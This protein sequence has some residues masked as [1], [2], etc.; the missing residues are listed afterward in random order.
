MILQLDV[1][2]IPEELGSCQ[3]LFGH[4]NGVGVGG[5]KEDV[6][7]GDRSLHYARS[8]PAPKVAFLHVPPRRTPPQI[9]QKL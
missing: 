5:R 3:T 7:S 4:E 6:F 1:Q 9:S 2:E 8:L